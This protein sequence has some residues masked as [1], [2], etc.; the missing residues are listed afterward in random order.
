MTST[1][2]SPRLPSPRWGWTLVAAALLLLVAAATVRVL[3]SGSF[4]SAAAVALVAAGCLSA[5]CWF[6]E[7]GKALW[8]IPLGLFCGAMSFMALSQVGG[9]LRLLTTGKTVMCQVVKVEHTTST[10]GIGSKKTLSSTTWYSMACPQGTHKLAGGPRLHEGERAEV[11]YDPSGRP[12]PK[13]T[14]T[15][16]ITEILKWVMLPAFVFAIVP[17]RAWQEGRRKVRRM[18]RRPAPGSPV[19]PGFVPPAPH[20]PY[21]GPPGPY[22]GSGPQA[23]PPPYRPWT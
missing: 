19:Q 1:D 4:L 21:M 15:I 3:F 9:D 17:I 20:S 12:A 10:S 7:A 22:P 8:V 23:P 2:S 13:I 5:G 18:S 6:L 16:E 11:T 14:E